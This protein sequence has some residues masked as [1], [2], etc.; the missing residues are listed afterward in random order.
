MNWKLLCHTGIIT[1]GHWA[2]VMS[3][4]SIWIEIDSLHSAVM[5]RAIEQGLMPHLKRIMQTG[6]STEVCYEVPLQISAWATAHTGLS[7]TEHGAT[8]YDQCIPGTYRMRIKKRP[9]PT[10]VTYWDFLSKMGK[11][12]LI[13]NSVNAIPA[14]DV[15][16]IQLNDWSVHVTGRHFEPTSFPPEIVESLEREFPD[17]PFAETDCGS[18]D[19]VDAERLVNSISANLARKKMAFSKLI[20]FETWDHVHIGI[21]DLHNLGHVVWDAFDEKNPANMLVCKALRDTDATIGA[22]ID[23]AGSD[24]VAMILVLGGIGRSNTWSHMVDKIIAHFEGGDADKA[25]K[26]SLYGVLGRAW[27][28]QPPWVTSRILPLKSYLREFYLGA[29]RRRRRAFAMPLNE[30]SGAIRI[31]LRGREPNG[32]VAPGEEYETLVSELRNAFLELRDFESGLPLVSKVLLARDLLHRPVDGSTVPDIFLEWN[33]A[34]RMA[35]VQSERLGRIEIDFWPARTGDHHVD[36]LVLSNR[37]MQ[38]KRDV[39]VLDLAPTVAALHGI[40]CPEWR[41]SA[42]ISP[43]RGS[44]AEQYPARKR[45]HRLGA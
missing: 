22:I 13:L 31:N 32:L 45:S 14:P 43:S 41:G 23:R 34:R 11:R 7:V 39:S 1:A 12:V 29:L 27:V 15:N 36:G 33:R 6:S 17:D 38:R 8:A 2:H 9:I 4:R 35:S 5:Q 26:R 16:G 20:D 18:S 3:A 25:S 37:E 30:E 28:A 19:F 24:A 21:D 44:T 10:G 40:K 42:F